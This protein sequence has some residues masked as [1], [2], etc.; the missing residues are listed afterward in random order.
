MKD[1]LAG[2]CGCRKAEDFCFGLQT[3]KVSIM[4]KEKKNPFAAGLLNMLIPGSGYLYVEN[5]RGRFIKILIGGALLIAVLVGLSIAIQNVRGYSLPQGLCTGALLLVVWV[6]LFLAGQ[7]TARLY[8]SMMDDTAQYN[9]RRA[10]SRGS[11]DAKLGKIQK[12]RDEGLISEEEYQKK[13][14]DLSN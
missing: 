6:P 5:D 4:T 1:A 3:G 14:D 10:V 9:T 12:M 13:K 8:N 11:K 7:K 2:F